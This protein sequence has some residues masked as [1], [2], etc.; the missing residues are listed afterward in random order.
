MLLKSPV[1]FFVVALLLA[2]SL[3]LSEDGSFLSA[4][5]AQAIDRALSLLKM[6]RVDLTYNKDYINWGKN[7]VDRWRLSVIDELLHSPLTIPEYSGKL[8]GGIKEAGDSLSSFLKVASSELDHPLPPFH[9]AMPPAPLPRV[10][11][12]LYRGWH[13]KVDKKL[14]RRMERMDPVLS[15]ALSW[16][17]TGIV[18]GRKQLD[19]AFR[20]FEPYDKEEVMKILAA[21]FDYAREE[22]MLE[23]DEKKE[24]FQLLDLSDRVYYKRL[25]VGAFFLAC[26]VERAVELLETWEPAGGRQR[27]F[28]LDLPGMKLVVGT[29]DADHYDLSTTVIIDPGGDDVYRYR[30]PRGDPFKSQAVVIDLGGNDYY[31]A[32][33][34]DFSLG[35]AV[36]G[37][38]FLID[39]AGSDTYRGGRVSL[40]GGLFGVGGLVD[41]SGDD[42]YQSDACTQGAGAFGAGYLYDAEGEDSYQAAVYAQGFAYTLGFGALRDGGGSDVYFAGGKYPDNPT[43]FPENYLS[44]SQGFSIGMRPYASGGIGALI[45]SGGNDTYVTEVYGQGSSYWFSLG[46]LLDEQGHDVYSSLQYSQGTGIHLSTGILV[47]LLGNDRYT[48]GHLGQG[49]DHDLSAAFLIDKE[50]NDI[51]SG[52]ST[53]Q[54]GALTNSVTFFIDGKGDDCYYARNFN[55]SHGSATRTRNFGGAGVFLDLEGRDVY[56]TIGEGGMVH[57]MGDGRIR[58]SGTYGVSID[59]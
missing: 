22:R 23:E 2:A 59:Y 10:V 49:S 16:V 27:P 1:V 37:Y 26:H 24:T 32:A 25:Y 41:L 11:K 47:D 34:E 54:G 51:Y 5:E 48:I 33:S 52:N 45:D 17:L 40:G 44:L 55:N 6:D 38:S 42:R 29:T 39:R 56:T 35:G 15:T 57:D 21:V 7:V 50:G 3:S 14:A 20:G 13:M 31:D 4:E 53:V 19:E 12:D 18:E 36:T 58:F 8:T 43:R 28:E 46:I 30:E 9:E